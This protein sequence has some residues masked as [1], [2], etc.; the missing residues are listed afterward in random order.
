MAQNIVLS[1][2]L[3]NQ[4][5]IGVI[6]SNK[7]SI[8]V[9]GTTVTSDAAGVLSAT[10]SSLTYDPATTILTHTGGDGNVTNVNLSSL[11]SDIFVNG[12]TFDAATSVLTLSDNDPA[13]PDVV[14]DLSTLLG[15]SADADNIL[16]DGADGKPFLDKDSIGIVS[17][18]ADNLVSVGADGGAFL[19]CDVIKTSCTSECT[20]VFGTPLF[21]AFDV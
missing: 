16:T 3:S 1:T 10:P 8:K 15:V 19:D 7:I 6:E 12:G 18:D 13:T 2:E 20:S 4:F 5:D 21:N 14:I 11:T 9:D 17:A